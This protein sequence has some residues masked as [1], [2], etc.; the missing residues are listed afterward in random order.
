MK[1]NY[2]PKILFSL[3][4]YSAF[5]IIMIPGYLIV[6]FT[7]TL[8][9]RRKITK[10]LSILGLLIVGQKL[11]IYRR[12]NF[13]SNCLFVANHSS[14]IDAMILAA[15]LPSNTCF[16]IKEEASKAPI[17]GP[18]LRRLN[19][20]FVRRNS[21]RSK[22]ESMKNIKKVLLTGDS[23]ALFP[24]GTFDKNIGIKRFH[25]GG[26][27]CVHELEIPLIPIGIKGARKMLPSGSWLISYSKLT[28]LLGRNLNIQHADSPKA[29]SQLAREKISILTGEPLTNG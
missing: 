5:V 23:V 10:L 18:F 14:L 27:F 3:W 21:A 13:Q 11:P 19:P 4:A 9:L 17:V 8:L 26:F 25:T 7:P 6:L 12:K 1:F 2:I 28:T 20:L 16:L 29:L 24:E 15:V 22:L